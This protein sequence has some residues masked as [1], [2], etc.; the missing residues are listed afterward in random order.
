MTKT[1][2]HGY[3]CEICERTAGCG[4]NCGSCSYDEWQESIHYGFLEFLV[5]MLT[6]LARRGGST[7]PQSLPNC[8]ELTKPDELSLA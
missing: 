5:A 3:C 7:I 2:D 4:V 6:C 8:Y 1:S